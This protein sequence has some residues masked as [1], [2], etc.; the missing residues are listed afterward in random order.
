MAPNNTI[1]SR[2]LWEIAS[3]QDGFF[4]ARQ[5]RGV[6]Y[7]TNGQAYQVKAGNWIREHRGIY[8]FDRYPLGR[9]PDLMKWYLWSC[10]RKGEPQGVYSHETALSLS[11]VSDV[12]PAKIHM[13]VPEAFRRSTAIPK[14]LILHSG[15]VTRADTGEF[16]GM[17]VTTPIRTLVD[18]VNAGTLSR[19]LLEQAA[20]EFLQLGLVTIH[21]ITEARGRYP[22][23]EQLLT[24][25]GR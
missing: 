12:N 5:A 4:T 7:D 10:N 13:T 24:E 21:G 3:L 18:V 1:K 23:V 6:G 25:M 9:H 22:A 16:H 20:T 19:D 2:R 8:R 11:E 14:I 15:L 17:F